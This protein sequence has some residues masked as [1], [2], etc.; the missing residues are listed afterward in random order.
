MSA[1]GVL[2]G[3]KTIAI[4]AKMLKAEGR[5]K[6]DKVTVTV[7]SN[8]G[9]HK[10]MEAEGISVDVT[11]VGDRYVLEQMLKTGCVIGGEQSGHIIFLEHTTT[12]DGILSSLQLVKAVLASGRKISELADEIQIYPQVLVNAKI[13]NDYKKTYM[14]DEEVAMAD[15]GNW[16]PKGG[17][18][19]VLIR[20][21][22]TE[23]LCVY[24]G[25]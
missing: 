22:G 18:R 25:R 2:D 9:F 17:E 12:G 15:C 13:N 23:H 1:A 5:L 24:A 8:I 4:C 20:P 10:A 11:G 3:D 14:K 7:M 21:S 19:R 16:K 6:D